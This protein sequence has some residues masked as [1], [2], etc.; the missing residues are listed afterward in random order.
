MGRPKQSILK[1]TELKPG[2]AVVFYS[3]D[4][5]VK[6]KVIAVQSTFCIVK[7]NHESSIKH[8]NVY[9]TRHIGLP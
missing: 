5:W 2:Q 7:R 3:G 9:D 1:W 4:G 6:G 8:V